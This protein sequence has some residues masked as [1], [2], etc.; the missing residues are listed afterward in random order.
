MFADI[1]V[2]TET[3]RLGLHANHKMYTTFIVIS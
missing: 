3:V 2:K 1:D